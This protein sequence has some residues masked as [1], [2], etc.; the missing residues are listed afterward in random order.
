VALPRRTHYGV[1]PTTGNTTLASTKTSRIRVASL[2][3]THFL[4]RLC[5]MGSRRKNQLWEIWLKLASIMTVGSQLLLL[6]FKYQTA[7]TYLKFQNSNLP[8]QLSATLRHSTVY[9][10]LVHRHYFS[11]HAK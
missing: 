8:P 4:L 3:L 6:L 7:L 11:Q 1:R 5:T 2:T 9:A 10:L